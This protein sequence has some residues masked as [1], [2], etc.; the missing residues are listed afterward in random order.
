[1]HSNDNATTHT[2]GNVTI[3]NLKYVSLL[4]SLVALFLLCAAR[5]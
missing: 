2:G 1:M 5:V 3:H 4:A